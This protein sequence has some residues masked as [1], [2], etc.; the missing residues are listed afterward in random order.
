VVENM[1]FGV[2][3]LPDQILFDSGALD[4]LAQVTAP[5]GNRVLVCVDPFIASTPLFEKAAASLAAAGLSVQLMTEIVPEL[6]V[7]FVEAAA[8]KALAFGPDVI[9]GFGGGSAL[10]MAKLVALLCVYPTPLSRY[11]GENAVPGPILPIIAVPT[12]AGTGSEVT[13]VAVVSD[14]KRELK[15]GVSSPHLIPRFAIVDPRLTLGAPA[16]VTAHSGI[17]AFVHAIESYTAAAGTQ[18]WTDQLPVFVG[19]NVLGSLLA[20]EAIRLIG[21]NLRTAVSDPNDVPAH[22]AMAYGSLLAGMAF[23]SA[24][25]HFSHALQYP[26]GAVSKTPHGLGTGMMLPYVLAAA[27]PAIEGELASIA[28]ALGVQQATTGASARAAVDAVRALVADIGIPRSLADIGISR[29]E[30]PR[31]AEL[32]L[33]VSRLAAN[34]PVS[35]DLALFTRILEAAFAGDLADEIT[36]QP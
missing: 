30:I 24:G 8:E 15:V 36:R 32:A 10:D 31:I 21:A 23:G 9:V 33:S 13:P 35:P 18:D 16:G 27:S 20:L 26:I 17:D 29:D 3:R 7:A 6:P 25:T 14:P 22:E 34:G 12:T 28:G 11:Y 19:R 2:V 4:S 1:G 5:F